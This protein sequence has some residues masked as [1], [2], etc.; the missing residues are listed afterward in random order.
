[1]R[2]SYLDSPIGTILLVGRPG[3]LT[4]LYVADHDNCPPVQA[5]W[6]EDDEALAEARAQLTEYFAGERTTFDLTLEMDGTPFQRQVWDA[7]LK[8]PFGET[9]SYGELAAHLGRP[10]S[11]RA[12]GA[13]NG[14]NPISVVVPCHRVIGAN[15]S[16][17]GF[18]W[19]TPRK[20]WLLDHEQGAYQLPLAPPPEE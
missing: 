13:A 16:L 10:G 9:W 5:G 12:V 6:V 2:Y 8:I 20:S 3:V 15:G 14:R 7:L 19:G 1:M 4:G 18:G 11:A 17:T